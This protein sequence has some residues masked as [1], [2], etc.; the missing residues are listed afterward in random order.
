MQS[1][2]KA[3]G[4]ERGRSWIM[5]WEKVMIGGRNMEGKGKVCEEAKHY[6]LSTKHSFGDSFPFPFPCIP[7][8]KLLTQK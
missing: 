7:K 3:V 6:F 8:D 5:E 2:T 4:N 1:E